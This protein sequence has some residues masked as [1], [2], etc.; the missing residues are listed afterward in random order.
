MKLS[1]WQSLLTVWDGLFHTD[2][3]RLN[4][5]EKVVIWDLRWPRTLLAL[6]IG[7]LL[8]ICGA[9][10]RACFETL[11]LIQASLVCLLVQGLG[12]HLPS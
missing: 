9:V 12:R 2:L 1:S 6:F 5:Y 7:A 11:W 10:T 3:S 8:A 4:D